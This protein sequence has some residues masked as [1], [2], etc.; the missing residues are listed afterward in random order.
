MTAS[1][2][3]IAVDAHLHVFVGGVAVGDARYVPTYDARLA[4]W[5]D[6]AAGVGVV[7]GVLVQ[8]SFLGTD[9]G[10]L[11]DHL[12]G[13]PDRFRG[14][15]VVPPWATAEELARL[16]AGGV[17]GLRINLAG[18]S[19]LMDE[20]A[21]A[22]TLWDAVASMGWHAE[23]HTDTGALPPVLAQLPA[24][25][26]LVIDHMGKPDRPSGADATDVAL[27]GRARRSD[28][29]VKLSGA[30]RLAGR[31]ATAVARV[32]LDALGNGRL[33]WG[34]DWPC[35]NHE[36]KADYPALFAQLADWVGSENVDAILRITPNRLYWRAD[37]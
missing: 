36:S 15:A 37:D 6:Q 24:Q 35:T 34:S 4:D 17:R 7:R 20:W 2:A 16:D 26:P 12:R 19:H 21:G 10:L 3:G 29:H 22:T 14:V 31:D 28:V 25:V 33:L 30:Y 13:E 32:W 27:V 5:S 11:L 9:N 1:A 8:P 23:I 18:R